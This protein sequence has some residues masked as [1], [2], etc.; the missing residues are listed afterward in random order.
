VLIGK[1]MEFRKAAK[2][3]IELRTEKLI[4]SLEGHRNVWRARRR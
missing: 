1:V 3:L 2:L 4:D